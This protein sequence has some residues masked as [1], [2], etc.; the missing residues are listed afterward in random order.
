MTDPLSKLPLF[1]T[2]DEIAIAIVGKARA[3]NWR[4]GALVL[5]EARGFPKVDAL[6][7]GRPV[8]LVRKWYNKYMAL[9]TRYVLQT[10]EPA[11]E[12]PEAWSRSKRQTRN[13]R[14]PQLGLST[15]CLSAL[16][17]MVTHPDIRTSAEIP[18]ARDFTLEQ[19]AS[20]GAVKEGKPDSQGDRTWTVTDLG[21]E[22]ITRINDWHHGKAPPRK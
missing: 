9:D 17:H 2:D 15:R 7:G 4:R 8:P 18:G 20:A 11:K 10:L 3:S 14:K 16:R 13:E 22:E 21:R 12:N 19:L 1:A 6:H 5:L